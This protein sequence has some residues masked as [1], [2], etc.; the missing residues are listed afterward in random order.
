MPD[1][2]SWSHERT[3]RL[4]PSEVWDLIW[5][6]QGQ[7]RWLGPQARVDF[8]PQVRSVLA[9]EAGVWRTARVLKVKG[10]SAVTM[11]ADA[12]ALWQTGG[13]TRIIIRLAG[14]G[15]SGTVVTVEES[16]IPPERLADV[17][18]FW[19]GRLDRLSGL[20]SRV[21]ARRRD[22]RQA[23]VVIHGIGEQQPGETLSSLVSSGVLSREDGLQDMWVK[24]D[25]FSDSFE[26]RRVT[27]EANEER[28]TT[29]AF[30]FYWAH[31]TSD[32][33]LRQVTSWMQRL[34]FRWPVPP[35]ILPWWLLMW[36]LVVL[37]VGASVAAL[38][39]VQL[40]DRVAYG[41]ALV[42]GAAALWQLLGEPLAL[43]FIGDAAR[44]LQPHPAN[45]A[46]RESIRQAGVSLIEKLHASGRY[47]RVVLLGH[48]LG[49]VIAYDIVTHAW[50][51]CNGE[52]RRPSKPKFTEIVAVEKALFDGT[53]PTTVQDLQHA[54]WRRL[55]ANTQ[56]WLVTD[57][58]TVG[59][60]LTY[61]DFLIGH[62]PQAFVQAKSD[63]VLPTCPPVV[64]VE[65]KTTHR[66]MTFD[67]P[68]PEPLSRGTRTFTQFHHAAPFA[69]TRW[70]NLYFTTQHLGVTGDLIGGPVARQL[71]AW[72]RDVPLASPARG[73][74]HTW[75]WRK[76]KQ[77]DA[78][79]TALR[80]ALALDA[81][82]SLLLLLKEIP[83]FALVE[84]AHDRG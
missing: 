45:I 56:P 60:P 65:P 3:V 37:G 40:A 58:V 28:P 83:A 31:V 73:F 42:A 46:H 4:G 84:R 68:Y 29:D 21:R 78:H 19:L 48:S 57:L 81:R 66:R 15:D 63:R 14:D 43:N 18:R 64:E 38:F 22:V 30:E 36:V 59:S 16:G 12:P 27:L 1:T 26:L 52:H 23:V 62:D 79:R 67:A 74:T 76:V 20:V 54:A 24:P 53:D 25:W 10:A 69:V 13:Q 71:G 82:A 51:R 70:T 5:R 55:R 35:P 77:G 39:G 33:T 47:D 75:Y 9:D 11:E 34:L 72:V 49:S 8:D 80:A 7:A 17:E 50:M 41:S 44:Y 6:P 61:A 2:A 32:T